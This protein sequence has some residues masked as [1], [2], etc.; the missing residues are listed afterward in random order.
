MEQKPCSALNWFEDSRPTPLRGIESETESVCPF[1]DLRGWTALESEDDTG[2]FYFS[3]WKLLSSNNNHVY[4]NNFNNSIIYNNNNDD[5]SHDDCHHLKVKHKEHMFSFHNIELMLK[6]WCSRLKTTILN[7]NNNRKISM[8]WVSPFPPCWVPL[9][10]A[11]SVH[12]AH[13]HMQFF[14]RYKCFGS[15]RC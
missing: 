13:R 2:A 11:V 6:A 8:F 12:R 15:W 10:G 14:T 1:D 3:T 7:S 4:Y 9:L 5:D